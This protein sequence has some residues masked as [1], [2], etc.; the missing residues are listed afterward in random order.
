MPSIRTTGAKPFFCLTSTPCPGSAGDMKSVALSVLFRHRR[1]MRG[2]HFNLAHFAMSFAE[3]NSADDQVCRSSAL[4]TPFGTGHFLVASHAM[5]MFGRARGDD[6]SD[7]RSF[8]C[9]PGCP[10]PQSGLAAHLGIG[11]HVIT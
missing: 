5:E 8:L 4:D 10:N 7:G 3:K 11:P 9:R 6:P 2:E 1:T